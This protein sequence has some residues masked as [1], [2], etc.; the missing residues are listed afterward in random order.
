MDSAAIDSREIVHAGHQM[1]DTSME[2]RLTIAYTDNSCRKSYS[3]M[4]MKKENRTTISLE[5]K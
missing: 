1:D 4:Y 5:M 3:N 2:Y